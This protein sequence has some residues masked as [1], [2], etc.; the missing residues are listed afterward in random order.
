MTWWQLATLAG[1][2]FVLGSSVGSFLNVCIWRLPRG[3]SL[4]RPGSRCPKCGAAISARDN[5]PVLGWLILRGRCRNCA[6]PISPRYPLVE[7]AVGLLFAGVF[8]ADLS[9]DPFERGAL[10]TLALLAC[11]MTLVA[12]LV[13]VAMIAR[14][15]RR[16]AE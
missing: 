6:G 11:H 4:I 8:V 5:V 2:G 3:E 12:V 1:F 16:R 13:T 9:P 14:D 10:S 15:A 7:A